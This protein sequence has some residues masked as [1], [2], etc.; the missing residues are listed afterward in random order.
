[1]IA[2]VMLGSGPAPAVP[3]PAPTSPK[4]PAAA[5]A[6][7]PA[8][9][10]VDY[11]KLRAEALALLRGTPRAAEPAVRVLGADALGD[12]RDR[13]ST[14]VLAGLV[15]KDPDDEVRGH[16]AAALG[17]IGL[18]R[19]TRALLAKLLGAAPPPL[20]VWLDEAL[21]RAGDADA[22]KRL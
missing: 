3:A 10:A 9:A 15:E 11:D 17:Q 2:A 4:T 5:P 22:R 21:A 8:P 20:Q 16:A 6:P 12:V 1:S 7:A 18:D 13:P 14:S 19:Q